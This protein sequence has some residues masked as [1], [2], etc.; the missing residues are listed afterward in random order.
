MTRPR[1][2]RESGEWWEEP[3]YRSAKHDCARLLLDDQ[4]VVE[5]SREA[6]LEAIANRERWL[7]PCRI[8]TWW[9]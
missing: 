4:R 2:W 9:D 6:R 1:P 8:D 3:A 7:G 5:I